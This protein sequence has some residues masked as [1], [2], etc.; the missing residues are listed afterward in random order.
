MIILP[1]GR[2][3]DSDVGRIGDAHS[4][5]GAALFRPTLDIEIGL[6]RVLWAQSP[7]RRNYP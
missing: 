5:E 4:A 7:G 1:Y 3:R 6:A 2:S